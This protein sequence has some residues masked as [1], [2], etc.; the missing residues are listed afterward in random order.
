MRN[1]IWIGNRLSD[2]NECKNLFSNSVTLYGESTSSNISFDKYR[3]NNNAMNLEVDQFINQTLMKL[4]EKEDNSKLMFYNPKKVY[5]LNNLIKKHSICLND[6]FLL[7]LLSDKISCH[8]LFDT[9]V[10]FAPYI[11]MNGKDIR[12]CNLKK[13]FPNYQKFVVQ[14]A[15]SSGGFGTFLLTENDEEICKSLENNHRYL[16]SAYIENNISFNF[17]V[18]IGKSDYLIFPPSIQIIQENQTR[19]SYRGADFINTANIDKNNAMEIVK[20]IAEKLKIYGYR[21]IVGLDMIQEC[22]TKKLYLVELNCRFQGSSF[23]VNKALKD[24]NLISLQE[25]NI[26]AFNGEKLENILPNDFKIDYGS[27]FYYKKEETKLSIENADFEC[28]ELDG[29]NYYSNSEDF[30]YLYKDIYI[31]KP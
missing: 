9:V 26:A 6:Y 5:S 14:Y 2:I 13:I 17:H 29:L 8:S 27:I 12:F 28:R 18:V 22:F 23:L 16:V 19:L 11:I 4:I 25:I 21:G 3:I 7:E 20:T 1:L 30:A 10:N 24:C 31:K 15:K